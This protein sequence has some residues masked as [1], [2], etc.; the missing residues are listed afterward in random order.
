MEKGPY[1]MEHIYIFYRL[2][3]GGC[4]G[5]YGSNVDLGNVSPNS[6]IWSRGGTEESNDTEKG[7]KLYNK[8]SH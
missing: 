4:L 6:V 1:F 5:W 7:L 8:V 3:F 2:S